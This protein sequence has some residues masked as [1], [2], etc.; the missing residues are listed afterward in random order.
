MIG[1]NN[2]VFQDLSQINIPITSLS[3]NRG[4]GGFEFFEI[5][6]GRPFYGDRHLNRFR[7]TLELLKLKISYDDQ[8]D[9]IVGDL[10]RRNHLEHAYMKLFA[11]PHA[12]AG[13]GFRDASLYVFPT[14]MPAFD[15][16]LYEEG[17]RLALKNFRRFMPEAKSTSYLA[18]QFWMDE[19]T[20][21][22]V[23]D[24][25]F[26]NGYSVQETSRGN[27]FVVKDNT[28]ITPADDVLMGVT[29]GL[30]IEL[31]AHHGLLHAEAEVSLALLNGADEVFL[32]ST[33]KHILPIV[34]ID[35]RKVGKGTPGPVTRELILAFQALKDAF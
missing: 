20:D 25:L 4:Y 22:R 10:I 23:V 30:V 5:I 19:Q 32:S 33:T 28:V 14:D 8:L 3:I 2:G 21:D 35:G 17:A 15:P 13:K 24:V 9:E 11:L 7:H 1:F 18:G 12:T 29:R 34:Q 31:L 27:V 16:V 26:H 6:H